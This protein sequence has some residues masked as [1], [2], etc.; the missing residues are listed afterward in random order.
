MYQNYSLLSPKL[1]TG[2]SFSS[3]ILIYYCPVMKKRNT[4]RSRKKYWCKNEH[5]CMI[6]CVS[7]DWLFATLW[8]IICQA[9]LSKGF[10]NA[11]Y[12]H[13]LLQGIFQIQGM[14][15]CF[16]PSPAL[17]GSFLTTNACNA[18]DPGLITGSRISAGEG[19]GYPL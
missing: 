17:A 10:S 18:G 7:R 11:V 14:N 4:V 5:A 15:W 2:I 3:L 19:I 8:I 13:I 12:C 9:P 1:H 6:S 16:F